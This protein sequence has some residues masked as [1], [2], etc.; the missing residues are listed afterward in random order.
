MGNNLA[1]SIGYVGSYSDRLDQTVLWNTATT[2]GPGTADQVNAL[3]IAPWEGTNFMGYSTGTANYNGLEVR[4]ERRFAQ[5]LYYLLSYTYSKSIDLGS[6]GWFD[7]ENGSGGGVQNAYDLKGSRSVSAYDI[8]HYLSMTGIYDL[9]FGTGKKYFNQHGMAS[10]LLGN[11]QLNSI[12]QLRSGVPYSM[13]VTGDV[14][15]IGNTVSWYNYA[16][17]NLVGNAN[18]SNPTSEEWFNP[19]AFA[20][21]SFSY[22]NV[23][24]NTLR[25]APCY[26]AYFSLF[27]NFPIREGLNLSFRAEFFNIFNI[28]NYAAPDSLVGDPAEGRVTSNVTA[29][30]QIQLALRLTF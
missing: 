17:P 3:R 22:G 2:S 5:G 10:R 8:P 11:W 18:V 15:N 27:K 4:L 1:L 25:S 28:Q 21:P 14:A 16:R 6:S 29:P 19:S 9:P 24:R 13:S 20:V 12:V 26:N 30:R 7:A 23:G